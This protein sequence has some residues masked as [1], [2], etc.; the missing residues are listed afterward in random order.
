MFFG[1][2]S[3]PSNRF[4]RGFGVGISLLVVG[5]EFEYG[6][7]SEDEIEGTPS[8]TTGMGNLLIQTPEVGSIQFYFTAGGGFYRERLLLQ[9]ETNFGLNTGGG[10]KIPLAGPLRL[11]VDYRLFR[12]Q[13]SPL[14]SQTHRFYAGVNLRF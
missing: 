4:T 2:M 13:G 1:T 6:T 3:N 7:V 10:V 11:R 14:Y 12:L 9:Q 8:L 5:F